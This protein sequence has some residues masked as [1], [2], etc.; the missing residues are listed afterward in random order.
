MGK[1]EKRIEEE[2]PYH[3]NTKAR[4]HERRGGDIDQ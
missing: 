2:T 1:D 4:K 3:E